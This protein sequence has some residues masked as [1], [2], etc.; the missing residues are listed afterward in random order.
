MSGSVSDKKSVE[1]KKFLEIR[2]SL[3]QDQLAQKSRM[4]QEKLYQLPEFI[5]SKVIHTYVSM[6]SMNEVSTREII[7]FCFEQDKRIVVP[8]IEKEGVLSHHL[9]ESMDELEK[10]SWGVGEPKTD[11]KFPIDSLSIVIV[12]MVSADYFKNRLGYGMGFYDR[13]LSQIKTFNVGVAFDCQI[14]ENMLPVEP[15]DKKLD[16]I[17][18]ESQKVQ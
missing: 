15:F 10:N 5:E 17:L 9:I 11:N 13:F 1:R 7:Q 4:I 12:P 8:K 14:S 18:T 3:S 2:N 16:I 6:S